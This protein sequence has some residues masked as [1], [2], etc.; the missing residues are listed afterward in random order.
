MHE[1][2]PEV[3]V[4]EEGRPG[5]H[6]DGDAVGERESRGLIHPAIDG[7]DEER[8]RD[9]R[10]H[11]RDAGCEVEPGGQPVPPVGVDGDEDRLDEER[12]ALEGEAEP[13]HVP[14][15]GHEARPQQAELEAEDRARDHAEREEREHHLRP[16]AGE[17][18]EQGIAGP[19]VAPLREQDHR[20]E[21]DPEADER[22]VHR[23]RE[24]LHLARLEQVMLVDR[25]ERGADRRED[26]VD[27]AVW[28]LQ[29]L[30]WLL[31][32][33]GYVCHADA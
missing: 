18:A 5:L 30:R 8:S 19:Q 21:R 31:R 24:R 14:E 22:D 16:A 1:L 4:R 9:A 15:R 32:S 23:Q 12:D 29:P 28:R 11:H 26:R 2:V 13:E 27:H 10:D 3:S 25:S 6:L 33:C 20:G 17:H 7:D